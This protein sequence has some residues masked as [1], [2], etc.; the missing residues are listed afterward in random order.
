MS[1]LTRIILSALALA[2]VLTPVIET[3]DVSRDTAAHSVSPA[4]LIWD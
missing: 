3:A 1:R 2:A 4:S